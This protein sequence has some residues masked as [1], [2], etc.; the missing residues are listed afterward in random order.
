MILL[1]TI[2]PP[3]LSGLY[4]NMSPGWQL[5]YLQ[6]FSITSRETCSPLPILAIVEKVRDAA[7]Y[8]NIGRTTLYGYI[9]Q[10]KVKVVRFGSSIRI[11]RDELERVKYE[12]IA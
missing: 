10:G 3:Y 8:L 9:R 2:R 7:N 11:S 12:G 4:S 5:R 1:G 6:I